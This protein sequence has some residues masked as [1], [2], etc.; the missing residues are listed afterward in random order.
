MVNEAAALAGRVVGTEDATPLEFWVAIDKEA[1]LQLDDVVAL[2]RV[3]PGGEV[4][5]IYGMVTQVRARHD[6]ARF[7]SDV[8]LVEGGLLPAAISEAAKVL[9]TRFEPET[10]VPP[11]PGA[12]VRKAHGAER[13]AAL[14]F[15]TMKAAHTDCPMGLSREN[16]PVFANL[17]FLD[18]S[19]GAHVNISGVSGVATKTTYALF[20]LY[21]LFHSGV[22]G[23]RR[24]STRALVFNVK[25]ED[26]LHLDQP[27]APASRRTCRDTA[28]WAC[29][30]GRSRSVRSG[31]PRDGASPA[32]S[33]TSTRR[34]DSV[35]SFFWTIEEFCREDLL[36]FLFAD[37]EDDRQQYTIVMHNVMARLREARPIGEGGVRIAEREVRTFR[38]LVSVIEA[39]LGDEDGDWRGHAI[40]QGTVN[41]FLRRLYSAR[42]PCRTPRTRRRAR[43]SRPPHRPG[44][45]GHGRGYPQPQ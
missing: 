36:P 44:Q 43:R 31:R 12:A 17:E 10:F 39:Q 2:E 11:L 15:D 34:N 45:P 21:S 40:T 25:G 24:L 29:P 28:T 20:L 30:R 41:A 32:P 18:G 14:Y 19:R 35:T 1:Y 42:A 4:I 27:N 6:G 16:D 38:E 26:L 33:P 5:R 23:E 22:L 9:A 37:A 7:D 8:F 13:D 3:L